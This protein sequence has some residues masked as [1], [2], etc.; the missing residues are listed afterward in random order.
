MFARHTEEETPYP[1]EERL[2]EDMPDGQT[3]LDQAG[4]NGY[5]LKRFRR[6]YTGKQMVKEQHCGSFRLLLGC[7]SKSRGSLWGAKENN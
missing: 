6:F 3:S 2:D 1:T 5:K 7:Y 4:F